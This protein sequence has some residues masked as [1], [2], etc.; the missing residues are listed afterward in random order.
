MLQGHLTNT[1]Q[2]RVDSDAAQVLASLPKDV[3]NSTVFG[4]CWKAASDWRY[5]GMLLLFST[6]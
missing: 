3:L 5:D 6:V 1:K 4:W 2:S